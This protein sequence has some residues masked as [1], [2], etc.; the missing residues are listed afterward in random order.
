LE[1]GPDHPSCS[2]MGRKRPNVLRALGKQEPPRTVSVEGITYHLREVFKH[3]SWAATA[4]YGDGAPTLLEGNTESGIVDGK[5]IVCKFN[6][7]SPI[8]LIP[9]GWLGRFLARREHY[10]LSE[11][12]NFEGIPE[13][14]SDVRIDGHVA[15][16]AVAHVFIEGK[17][18]SLCRNMT[19]EFFDRVERLIDRLH[20]R[21]I[22]YVDLHKQEN[23]IVG[24]DGLPY[25]IDFQV[26]MQLPSWRWLDPMFR[27]FRDCDRYHMSKHR[28][29]HGVPGGSYPRPWL[30]RAHRKFAVP[31]RTF[32]RKFLTWIGVRRDDGSP[33]TEIAPEVGL[34][35]AA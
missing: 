34:R 24:D 9:M 25:L 30:I 12:K 2:R 19:E 5:T 27:I 17:P 1:P 14:Y 7:Q 18:L 23:V 15:K 21:R 31:L 26:S 16:H 3:D 6:R 33:A 35:R 32:R 8:G 22:A 29:C 11:L 28:Q 13:V 4:K 10:F 20:E